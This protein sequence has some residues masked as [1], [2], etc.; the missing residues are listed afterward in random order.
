VVSQTVDGMLEEAKR[1]HALPYDMVVK[2]PPTET[3]LAAIRMIKAD[4]IR[5]L[6]TAVYIKN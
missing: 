4:N 1:L 5:V 3:G 6:A 2:V